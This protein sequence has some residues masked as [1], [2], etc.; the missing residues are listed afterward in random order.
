MVR[1]RIK[2]YWLYIA[3]IIILGL[4]AYKFM[5]KE[6]YPDIYTPR[7]PK[8]N[9]DASIVVQEFSDLQ[10]PACKDAHSTTKEI[11]EEFG[12]EI[13]LEYYHFPLDYHLMAKEAAEAAECANDLGKFWEFVD[14]AFANSP[15]LENKALKQ[16]ADILGL[17]REK[18]DACLDSG[19]KRD[20]VEMDKREG[21]N[22]G[23]QGTPTFFINGKKLNNRAY[24]S[25]KE[26]IEE[27]L[28]NE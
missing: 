16:Y 14:I 28:G 24:E 15:N 1:I 3:V 27:E 2:K 13:M 17:D 11:L 6:S 20:I 5:Y 21:I 8:G 4:A 26:A 10:C 19:A 25:F 22:K 9:P 7:P 23:V 18:F 12:D